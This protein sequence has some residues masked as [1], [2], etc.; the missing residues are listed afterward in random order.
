M[1]SSLNLKKVSLTSPTNR[2]EYGPSLIS[3]HHPLI[4]MPNGRFGSTQLYANDQ[5]LEAL[6]CQCSRVENKWCDSR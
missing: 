1:S 4:Y 6:C 3:A 2:N 5:Q